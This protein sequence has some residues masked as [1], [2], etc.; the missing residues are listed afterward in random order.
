MNMTFEDLIK[1]EVFE[2]FK[3]VP[4]QTLVVDYMIGIKDMSPL[5]KA[6]IIGTYIKIKELVKNQEEL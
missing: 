2:E 4:T 5:E 1:T 6:N 3:K